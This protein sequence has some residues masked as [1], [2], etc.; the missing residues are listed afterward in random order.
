MKINAQGIETIQ[1]FFQSI[2]FKD[3]SAEISFVFQDGKLSAL[4]CH[5]YEDLKTTKQRDAKKM[6]ESE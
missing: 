2:S 5:S 1:N 4:E 6:P 3:G